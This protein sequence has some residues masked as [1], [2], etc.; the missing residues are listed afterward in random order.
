MG[1]VAKNIVIKFI[2]LMIIQEKKMQKIRKE[3]MKVL[4]KSSAIEIGDRKKA[5]IYAMKNSDPYE[6]ILVAG[7]DMKLIKI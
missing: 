7:K 4:K 5:I 6:I 1:Q 3:I 2:L